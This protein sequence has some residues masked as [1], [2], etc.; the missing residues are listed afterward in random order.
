MKDLQAFVRRGQ[1]AQQAAVDA[2]ALSQSP[3][4]KHALDA[5]GWTEKYLRDLNARL[6]A[7]DITPIG[8]YCMGV[9]ESIVRQRLGRLPEDHMLAAAALSKSVKDAVDLAEEWVSAIQA[10][11]SRR[12]RSSA[13]PKG[14]A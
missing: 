6:H 10:R 4:F 7:P 14:G 8:A 11:E 5:A 2:G 9:V 3:A 12:A 13:K 1:A